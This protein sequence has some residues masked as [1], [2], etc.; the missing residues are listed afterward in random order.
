MMG[1]SYFV[2]S[3]FVI[4]AIMASFN[5]I[6]YVILVGENQVLSIGF[7]LFNVFILLFALVLYKRAFSNCIPVRRKLIEKQL[8]FPNL[9]V[10]LGT[11][12]GVLIFYIL[13]KNSGLN[14]VLIVASYYSELRNVEEVGIPIEIRTLNVFLYLSA[15]IGGLIFFERLII[16]NKKRFFLL[17]PGVLLVLE[18]MLI[19]T[20]S[21]VLV[22]LIYY[23]TSY[24]VVAIYHHHQLEFWRVLKKLAHIIS[25]FLFVVVIVH[26]IRSQGALSPYEIL[27]KIFTS[28][29]SLPMF[30]FVDSASELNSVLS[31]GFKTF[32]GISVYLDESLVKRSELIY[33]Y[34]FGET[35]QTNVYSAY[36]YL[37]DDFGYAGFFISLLTLYSAVFFFERKIYKGTIVLGVIAIYFPISAYILFSFA[38]PIFKYLTHILVYCLLFFYL[39]TSMIFVGKHENK[40]RNC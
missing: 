26:S 27:L 12:A 20:K 2:F 11:I 29:F 9:L 8:L 15:I 13:Y 10:A 4:A 39:A 37:M 25:I 21:I 31:I 35:M 3:P 28:Y 5:M 22:V 6:L 17:L 40:Y 36:Y 30:A 23:L 18:S 38:D 19:G 33:F 24:R 1:R 16:S 32:M 14:D 7:L 34:L